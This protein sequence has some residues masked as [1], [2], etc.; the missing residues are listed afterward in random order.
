[1]SSAK[2]RERVKLNASLEVWPSDEINEKPNPSEEVAK[3]M[4]CVSGAQLNSSG[5]VS[6]CCFAGATWSEYLLF[7]TGSYSGFTTGSSKKGTTSVSMT[8]GTVFTTT[9][10][11]E[12]LMTTVLGLAAGIGYAG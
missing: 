11:V 12:V 8:T 1:M 9:G 6:G 4:I 3:A 10:S 5:V 2:I 7:W